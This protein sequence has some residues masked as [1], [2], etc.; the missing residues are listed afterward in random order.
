MCEAND[1]IQKELKG[2]ISELVGRNRELQVEIDR[3]MKV[4]ENTSTSLDIK[5]NIYIDI[6][7]IC[8]SH[9]SKCRVG[10]QN[11]S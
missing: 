11:V 2:H 3:L 1:G 10:F 8:L 5:G 4:V 9:L 7:L 6:Y